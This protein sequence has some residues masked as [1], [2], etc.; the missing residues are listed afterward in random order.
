MNPFYSISGWKHKEDSGNPEFEKYQNRLLL[1]TH[2]IQINGH[3]SSNTTILTYIEGVSRSRWK[4]INFLQVRLHS[5]IWYYHVTSEISSQIYFQIWWASLPFLGNTEAEARTEK[6]P[7]S[8]KKSMSPARWRLFRSRFCSTAQLWD[9]CVTFTF[10]RPDQ[11]GHP[12]GPLLLSESLLATFCVSILSFS[13]SVQFLVLAL[14][15][16]CFPEPYITRD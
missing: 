12:R 8:V 15:T 14:K 4:L 5:C 13:F 6:P 7:L 3:I 2:T 11:W 16:E 10:S 9:L 1:P